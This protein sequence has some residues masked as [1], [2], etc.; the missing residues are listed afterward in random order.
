[1]IETN[2][3]VIL[4]LTR[5]V[6]SDVLKCHQYWPNEETPEFETDLYVLKLASIKKEEEVITSKIDIFEKNVNSL[7][8]SNLFE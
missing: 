4:M 1:M 3:C 6:E 8:T 5:V 7:F 2:S